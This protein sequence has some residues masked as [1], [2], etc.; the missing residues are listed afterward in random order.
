MARRIRRTAAALALAT[1]LGLLPAALDAAT[2]NRRGDA[3]SFV[4]RPGE[5]GFVESLWSLLTAFWAKA[6]AKIDGNG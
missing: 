1:T 5:R 3:P 4:Q 2:L 6:G